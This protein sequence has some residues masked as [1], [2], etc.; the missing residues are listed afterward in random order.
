MFSCR[1]DWDVIVKPPDFILQLV[2]GNMLGFVLILNPCLLCV[3]IIFDLQ[4]WPY[5]QRANL[6]VL[7]SL[8]MTPVALNQRSFELGINF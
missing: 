7:V 1:S 2:P 5:F 4:A 3:C 8:Y 6:V